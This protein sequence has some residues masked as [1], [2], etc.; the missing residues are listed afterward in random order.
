MRMRRVNAVKL[1]LSVGL[2]VGEW[3]KILKITFHD[4]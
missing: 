4:Y 3:I 2:P 1:R